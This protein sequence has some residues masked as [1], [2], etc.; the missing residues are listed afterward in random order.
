MNEPGLFWQGDGWGVRILY[1]SAGVA[2][3]IL[4]TT[5]EG[6]SLLIDAGD[7]TLRDLVSLNYDLHTLSAVLI[8][9]GH[10]DHIGG[11]HSLLGFMRMIGRGEDLVI[12]MP[13]GTLEVPAI[14]DAFELLYSKTM[15]FKVVR[16]ELK[17]SENVEF[18]GIRIKP[19][20]VIHCGSTSE[21]IGKE[22]PAVGYELTFA[23]QRIVYTGDA[24]LASN[25]ESRINGAD[26]L[27]IEATFSKPGGEREQRVH[28][29]L[30][31]SERLAKGAKR[32]FII[33]R[34]AG[35]EPL[36]MHGS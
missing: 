2:T 30:E 18:C 9:H 24:G 26:L 19:F 22:L 14:L 10:F 32:A 25:L 31:S 3:S 12:A 35:K 34:G 7:G 16:N 36:D 8:S 15:P 21:G 33:H 6:K 5:K 1:S 11:L 28:L 29:S 17:D 23:N 27:L 13:A 20:N 4:V